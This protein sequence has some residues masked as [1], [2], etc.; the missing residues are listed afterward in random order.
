MEDNLKSHMERN[1]SCDKIN[2]AKAVRKYISKKKRQIKQIDNVELSLPNA[3]S[4]RLHSHQLQ[5][6]FCHLKGSKL[7]RNKIEKINHDDAL[8]KSE[9]ETTKNI[10]REFNGAIGTISKIMTEHYINEK[11]L[12]EYERKKI[13]GK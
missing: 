12:H 11:R 2:T 4:Q 8:R 13:K 5:S 10:I 7:K 6:E 9:N 3:V 1:L